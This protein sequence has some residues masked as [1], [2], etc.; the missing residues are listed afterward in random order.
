MFIYLII[1]AF[2]LILSFLFSGSETAF[3][4]IAGHKE[5]Y[6]TVTSVKFQKHHLFIKTLLNNPAQLLSVILLANLLVNTTASSLFT[7]F[8]IKLSE[9]SAWPQNLIVSIGTV[10]FTIIL[11]ICGEITP[12]IFAVRQ[13]QKLLKFSLGLIK[14]VYNIFGV[15][16]VPLNTIG[17]KFSD[18]ILK[19]F[20][21]PPFPTIEE[22]KTFIEHSVKKGGLTLQEENFLINL[23]ELTTRRVSEVMTPRIKM[24][25]LNEDLTVQET[26]HLIFQNKLPLISRIP[27]YRKTIDHITGILYIKD[28]IV[29]ASSANYA[30][31]IAE[32]VRPAYFVYESKTL[33]ELLEEL[34]KKDSHIAIVI[35]EYGQTAGLVTLEDILETLVGEIQ[36]EYDHD[37][38]IPYR[39]IDS[40]TFLVSG[41]IDLKTLD[42]I[43]EDFSRLNEHSQA[44]R[45]SGF[46]LETWGKIPKRG[47]I[48]TLGNY[49]IEINDIK[50]N[51]IN[52]VLITKLKETD[53]S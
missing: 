16:T 10:I 4:T 24:I 21:T 14:L 23:I 49:R 6:L 39:P 22:I 32:F 13:P 33:D 53:I 20:H 30:K 5:K 17:A 9:T 25:C 48:L 18:K 51:L 44:E 1:T 38:E 7:L 45:L 50:R 11:I 43:F 47:E 2:L 28:L 42:Q 19:I 8:A 27:V 12:K 41:D 46:I 52:K 34:R 15:F 31:R 26:L 29:I 36:D 3:F 37:A 35:D 40:Q